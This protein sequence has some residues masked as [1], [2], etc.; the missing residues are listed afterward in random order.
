[1]LDIKRS[2][3]KKKFYEYISGMV[4]IGAGSELW[5]HFSAVIRQARNI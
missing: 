1:M 2:G 3:F 5:V 4:A